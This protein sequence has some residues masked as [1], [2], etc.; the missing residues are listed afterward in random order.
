MHLSTQQT[1]A[2]YQKAVGGAWQFYQLVMTQWPLDM[3]QPS[4][5][6]TPPHTF[7]GTGATTSFANATLETWDQ[8]SIGTGCMACHTQAQ[9]STDFLWTLQVNAFPPLAPVNAFTVAQ[10]PTL[11]VENLKSVLASGEA[12]NKPAVKRKKPAAKTPNK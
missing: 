4:I 11:P 8:N 3:N 2:A 7:P 10:R 5:P 12:A 6:G 1:N 9:K